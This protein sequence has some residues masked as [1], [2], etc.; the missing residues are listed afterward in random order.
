MT[1][2]VTVWDAAAACFPKLTPYGKTWKTVISRAEHALRLWNESYGPLN[3][4]QWAYAGSLI[5]Y[6]L[7]VAKRDA[8]DY[9]ARYAYFHTSLTGLLNHETVAEGFK[10]RRPTYASAILSSLPQT[11]QEAT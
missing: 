11:F 6:S 9:S 5:A 3:A 8:P 10:R 1:F 2:S 7:S 4:D